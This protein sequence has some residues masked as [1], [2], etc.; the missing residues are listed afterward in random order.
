[1]REFAAI[2]LAML[3]SSLYGG[4]SALQALEARRVPTTDALRSSLIV[5]LVRRPLW[6]AGGAA[7]VLGWVCSAAALALASV[8]LVQPALGLGLIVLLFLATRILGE[9]V[10]PVE[11]GGS[12]AIVVAVAALAWA[13]PTGST[14]FTTGGTWAIAIGLVLIV[15]APFALRAVGRAGGLATSV[16]GGLGWAAVGLATAL[17]VDALDQ[18]RWLVCIAW[19]IGVGL[20]S[21]STLI[22]EMSALQFWPATRSI[23]IVFSLEMAVPAA[24]TPLLASDSAPPHP[25]VFSFALVI[26]CA[27]AVLVGRSRGV[28]SQMAGAEAEAADATGIP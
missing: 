21:W 5:R 24:L 10:G 3:S 8:A 4:A 13:G 18:H 22:S 9:R 15:G 16:A 26:A 12:V 2:V 17:V 23:P 20:A 6:L 27:G 14:S 11:I 28:A 25:V 7:G 1:V 19:A